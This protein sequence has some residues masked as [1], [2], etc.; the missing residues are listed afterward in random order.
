LLGKRSI[1]EIRRS[2]LLEVIERIE[3]RKALSIARELRGWF[4]QLFRF[5]LV[6]APGLEYNPATDLDIVAVPRPPVRH[7]PFLHMHELLELL[8]DLREYPGAQTSL[9]LR[10]LLLTGVRTGELRHATSERFDLERDL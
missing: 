6:K 9:G 1:H 2:D 10:L 4:N 3:R 7:H 5:A 8:R